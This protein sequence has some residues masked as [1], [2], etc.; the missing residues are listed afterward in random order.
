MMDGGDWSNICAEYVAGADSYK[1]LA[2]KHGISLAALTRHAKDE[3]W[4]KQRRQRKTEGRIVALSRARMEVVRESPA[5]GG[6]AAPGAAEAGGKHGE[7]EAAKDG[8]PDPK[9]DA[10]LRV[11]RAIENMD[12]AAI[13]AGIRRKALLILDRMFDD[14]AEVSA[15]EQRFTED[16][17]TNVRKLRDM[18][19]VYKELMNGAVKDGE[20]DEEDLSPL[21]EL[22]RD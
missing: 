15:T 13:T 11:R 3:E 16:G 14:Y 22:L 2:E 12:E 10:R 18:T 1:T 5:G 8:A 17:V 7:P 19:A 4:V 20:A 21:E 9:E 6:D